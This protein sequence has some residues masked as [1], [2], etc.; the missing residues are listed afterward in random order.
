MNEMLANQYFLARKY[1][2]AETELEKVILENPENL[3]ARKKLIIC[4]TQTGKFQS[5]F[6]N[7]IFIIEKDIEVITKTNIIKDDC[8][9]PELILLINSTNNY[10]NDKF[11][12]YLILGVLWLYCDINKSIANLNNA[13][14]INP[15][16]EN[17][18]KVITIVL[19][20]KNSQQ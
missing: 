12:T 3:L 18:E 6:T 8:P 20:Y 10:T 7:F 16:F 5:A 19:G 1:E 17:L 9:C 15:K 2:D 11:R 4:N 13:L 14:K